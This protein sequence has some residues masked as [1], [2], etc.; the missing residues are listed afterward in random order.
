MPYRVLDTRDLSTAGRAFG[1][2]RNSRLTA[3]L[4][5]LEHEGWHPVHFIPQG[6]NWDENGMPDGIEEAAFVFYQPED[7]EQQ[8]QEL[9]KSLG[10]RHGRSF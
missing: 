4:N 9:L 2:D 6:Q 5:Q 7:G 10:E 8:K 3:A 1:Q